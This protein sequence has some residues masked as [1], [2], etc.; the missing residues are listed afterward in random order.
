MLPVTWRNRVESRSCYVNVTVS[1]LV[2]LA[3]PQPHPSSGVGDALLRD[4]SA[5]TVGVV[6]SWRKRYTSRP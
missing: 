5:A 1:L 6:A 2:V 4:A 3:R